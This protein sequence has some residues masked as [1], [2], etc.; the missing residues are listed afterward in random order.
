MAT[1]KSGTRKGASVT[2]SAKAARTPAA[3]TVVGTR[4][5]RAAT[6]S[7]AKKTSTKKSR[8]KKTSVTAHLQAAAKGAASV[9]ARSNARG[10]ATIVYVHGI[11]NKP[12]ASIL[13]RQWDQA[14]FEFDLGECSRMAYWVDRERYPAPLQELSSGGDYSD[15][16]EADAPPGE[17]SARAVRAAWNTEAEIA[18]MD[19]HIADLMGATDEA[20][21]DTRDAQRFRGIAA[22]MLGKTALTD[23]A[24]YES[25]EAAMRGPE[26]DSARRIQAQRYGAAAVRA[27]IFGFLPRPMRQWLTRNVTRMLLRDVHDLFVDRTKGENMKESLRDRLRGGGGPFVLVAHS[28]GT[29]IAYSVLMEKEFADADVALLVT[30]GSPLGV[31]EAQDFIK[32]LTGQKKL[33]V[34]R[35]VRRWINVCDPLDPVALDKDIT[36]EFAP[37]SYGVSLENHM[38]FNPDSPRHPHSST[39]YL[40][41]EVVRQPVREC[42]DTGLF[43]PVARFKIAKDVVRA[44]A[45]S[46]AEERHRIL[47]QLEDFATTELTR[48]S[49]LQS[50]YEALGATDAASPARHAL[51]PEE[52]HRYVALSLT[53][54][55]AERLGSRAHGDKKFPVAR[56]WKNSAK[57]AYLDR[58]IHTTQAFPAHNSYHAAGAKVMW[59]VLDSGIHPTHPHFQSKNGGPDTIARVYDC[60]DAAQRRRAGTLLP[61]DLTNAADARRAADRY[62]HGAHVAGII[63]GRHTVRDES[64]AERSMCGMAPEARLLIYKVLDNNGSGEDSWIIKAL[65]HIF[66]TNERAGKVVVHGVNLSL[67]GEFDVE[68]FNAGHTPLC[69]ELRRL[70]R[71]GVVVVLAAGNEGFASLSTA[72]GES[73]QANMGMSIGDPAN[74]EEAIVVGSV[75]KDSPHTYGTSFFSSRGPTADGRMKPDCV[76]PGERILSVRNDAR[77]IGPH[78]TLEALYTEMSGTSMAAPHV[79]GL[80]AAFLSMRTEFIGRPDDEKRILLSNCTD[81][82]R[83]RNMQGAGMPNL[84]KMLVNV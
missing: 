2:K 52:L 67:G 23:D 53:R 56:I 10:A 76:A 7:A 24:Q 42:V 78:T 17:F 22:G 12:Q 65:D 46:G 73:I 69:V 13:K 57:W 37:N 36:G 58:S 84:V 74:L 5:K 60:T 1:K 63:A 82:G 8:A 48:D 41:M 47:V 79:S 80:V 35:G 32:D 3:R 19:E 77:N 54:R 49:A 38:K 83:Q 39:G 33:T 18:R 59:A 15:E 20:A 27:K 43:Q 14:L 30:V 25:Y 9:A 66:E 75:H 68:A 64:G 44:F 72:E 6:T 70:W 31:Q 61:L 28:Q 45:D 81:L 16:M 55:E 21:A 4:P 71:Q 62:G 11:G 26:G 29:M 40:S 51:E 34:P 50:I